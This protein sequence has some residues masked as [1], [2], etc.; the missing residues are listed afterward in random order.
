MASGAGQAAH[1]AGQAAHAA[2]GA[3]TRAVELENEQVIL[4]NK[5]LRVLALYHDQHRG[6]HLKL[7]KDMDAAVRTTLQTA[8]LEAFTL[9]AQPGADLLQRVMDHASKA[10]EERQTRAGV[11]DA[12]SFIKACFATKQLLSAADK[13]LRVIVDG[14]Q[15]YFT[16][17]TEDGSDADSTARSG[18]EEGLSGRWRREGALLT[19]AL[20]T[21]TGWSKSKAVLCLRICI[22]E[23][24]RRTTYISQP[25]PAGCEDGDDMPALVSGSDSDDS[26]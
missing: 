7:F 26:E 25:P 5:R 10:V 14:W 22:G 15:V 2:L 3:Y 24:G 12:V 19:R 18:M 4:D 1:A 11:A 13:D 20:T 16:G 23:G 8:A 9:P 21:K 17:L 6:E